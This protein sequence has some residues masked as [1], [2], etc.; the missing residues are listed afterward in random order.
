MRKDHLTLVSVNESP[1]P[2]KK[3][4]PKLILIRP[5]THR[6]KLRL[7]VDNEQG[8]VDPHEY[9]RHISYHQKIE[10]QKDQKI[11]PFFVMALALSVTCL[12]FN[13]IK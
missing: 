1:A 11:N 7:V 12:I 4:K 10:F 3:T 5:S 13:Y 8:W 2:S 9:P 6:A